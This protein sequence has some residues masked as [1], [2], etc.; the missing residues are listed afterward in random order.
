MT[1]ISL[2][3]FDIQRTQQVEYHFAHMMDK[4]FEASFGFIHVLPGA[5]SGY[6]MK[7]I[8]NYDSQSDDELLKKYFKSIREKLEDRKVKSSKIGTRNAIL[9]IALPDAVNSCCIKIDPDSD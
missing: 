6:N 1:G 2:R 8:L 5:F 3:F 4:S 9:R 7:A